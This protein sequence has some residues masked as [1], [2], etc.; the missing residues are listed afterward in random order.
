MRTL[1]VFLCLSILARTMS[2]QTDRGTLTGVI[3]DPTGAVIPNAA[4]SVKNSETG[5]VF[6]GGTSATGNYT[7]ALPRGTYEMTATVTGFKKY[8]RQNLEI[9]VATTVR[10][11]VKLEVGATIDTI[12]VN[13]TT[14]LLKTESG[15]VSYNVTSDRANNLP[16]LTIGTSGT[17]FGAIRNPLQ[18]TTLLP[19]T[20]FAA[21]SNL[22]VNGLP[23]NT[24]TIRVEGQDASNG[25]WRQ[26]ASQLQQGMEAIQEVAVQTSNFAA[27]YGQAAG[28]YFNF[29][30]KSGT[31]QYHGSAY[32]YYVNEFL[33]AGTPYTDAGTTDSTKA[34]QHVRNRQ[35]RNDYGFTLGGPVRI[36]KVY[37]GHD[38]TFFFFNWEQYRETRAISNGL[39]TV[40]TAAYR[41]GDF[42]AATPTCTA[43]AASCVGGQTILTQA[44]VAVKD[45]LGRVI[46]QAG[47][48]DP[49]S[50]FTAQDGTLAR[51]LF[52]N[53]R[54]PIANMDKVA[55]N[56]QNL[57]PLPTNSA[58]INNY[59]IPYYTNPK[60]TSIPSIKIDHSLSPTTKISGYLSR[61][62]TE[63]PNY[64]GLEP[65]LTGVAAA[66]NRSTTVRVNYDQTITP[67]VLLHLGAGY[68]YLW[69]PSLT[70]PFDQST[71]GLK[72]FYS[73]RF[74]SFSGLN[75]ALTGGTTLA[76]GAGVFA[77]QQQWDQKPTANA[78]LTWVK[79]NHTFKF[80]AEM[81]VDGVIN[82]TPARA[83]GI[84]TISNAQTQNPW[85]NGKTGLSS[86]SGFGYASFLL[87]QVQ[88]LQTSPPADMRLGNHAISWFAQDTWKV[89]RKLTLDYGIRY[90]FQ[91]Y[92]KE[93]YGRMQ[94]ADY[95]TLNTKVGF[96][97]TVKYEGFGPGRCN[98]NFSNNYPWAFG[99]RIG[100]AYQIDSKTVIRGGT[101]FSYGTAS[102]NSFL[103]LSIADFYTINAPGFGAN[104]LPGGLQGGNPYAVGNPYGN[105]P[106]VWPNFDPY[107][108]PTRTVCPGTVNDTCYAPQS[109]FISIDYDSRPPRIFQYSLSLQRE[110][111]RNL[112]VEAAYVGN[113]GVWFTAPALNTTAYN[114][115]TPDIL[116]AYGLDI[117]NAA[118]RTLLTTPMG[119]ALTLQLTPAITARGFKLPYAGFPITQN[120][121]TALVPRPQ[122]GSTIPPFLGPPLGK[123][124]Y[125]ALQLSVTKRYSHGLDMQGSFTYGKEESLGTN[126]DSAYAGVPA[127]TRINDVF[128][129]DSN[130]QLSPLS[131]PFKVVISGTYTT[132]RARGDGM[133]IKAV[134]HALRDWQLG[135]VL[136][137]QSGALL[138][139]PDS[140]NQLFTQL[141]RGGGLFSGGAT[142]WNFAPGKG[143]GDVFLKDPNCHCFDPTQ[144][145]LFNPAAF[146]DAPAGQYASTAAYYNN[147]RWQRQPSENVNLGRNFRMG[148]EGKM[149][150][151]IRAEFQN[152]F[153]R[154]FYGTP[155]GGGS[156]PA[157]NPTTVATRTNP[158]STLS[159][160]FGYVNW[161]N[162]AGASPRTG[163]MVARFTF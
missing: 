65:A 55:L 56:I 61:T 66:N 13:D 32:D 79:N 50:T 21:D 137:Y 73:N 77:N 90:D 126:A 20:Q 63:Q 8:V 36:P 162:G 80:G 38:K 158:N 10:W 102:N 71:I 18:I 16:V 123:T 60:T 159:G 149:N 121:T 145:L 23:S 83:N 75:N 70:T 17:G 107:K 112:V 111:V 67:T 35:R 88:S 1:S 161:L 119:S 118:D 89:T 27:E 82:N 3:T 140:L 152:I 54:I 157:T 11:D 154:H 105:P 86:S 39:S 141:N 53:N 103:S 150:L 138:V 143:P 139:L 130:K 59:N 51:N 46:P 47:V 100:V 42:T 95:N 151:Q 44:G 146:Q 14:P 101:G 48:Y 96:P 40:P 62:L 72:G 98:C 37:D 116:K 57:M 15:E 108:Y 76:S 117:N 134:S 109:P 148:H 131:R 12:T 84:F 91:T 49:A 125:D 45:Q 94:S 128:N 25:L 7:F 69:A 135:A 78:N 124:W 142:Y 81:I 110:V 24:G 30:M 26:Q 133:A 22:R 68:L 6:E 144:E 19:G 120:L 41:S 28:G 113:R 87:G 92:L 114:T 153:N 156:I 4:I 115:L 93:Q 85:E 74:P 129:R 97:G 34:G 58:L 64:N 106:L 155:S 52:P 99:P 160:G 136:Q 29:T 33:N 132:P 127:T 2:G 9:P 163:L 147:I 31:N 104:A 122:W 43:T 5:A